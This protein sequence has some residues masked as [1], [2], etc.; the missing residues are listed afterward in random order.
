MNFKLRNA[1]NQRIERI[2]TEHLVIGIDIAKDTHV[3]RAVN[4]RGLEQGR[5]CIFNNHD[6]GFK[7]LEDWMGSLRKSTAASDVIIGME[8]TGHYWLSL[9]ESLQ[10][11]GLEVVVVNPYHVKRNKENRDNSPTKNDLKDALVIA[12]M[13]KNGYYSPLRL[14]SGHFEELRAL[15]SHREFIT[16]QSVS[17]QNQIHRWLAMYFPEYYEVFKDWTCKTSLA[18][19]KLFP[20]P[21]DLRHLRPED[22]IKQWRPYLQRMT[23]ITY[24]QSLIDQARKS[25]GVK[26]AIGRAKQN[27]A[28]LLTLY[29]LYQAQLEELEAQIVPILESIPL[30]ERLL[31]IKGSSITLVSS[32]LAEAGDLRQFEHGQ[33]LLRLAGLHLGEDSSGKHKGQIKITKRG[34]PKLRKALYL[35]MV[36]LVR[37]NPEFRQLHQHNKEVKKIKGIHSLFKLIGKFARILVSISRRGKSYQPDRVL[38]S[39]PP[40][41][42][43]S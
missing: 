28:Q 26:H 2:S 36:S 20:T 7:K 1:Q 10:S 27:L 12:D 6:E 23:S 3:A 39:L 37:N 35:Y 4:Y 9:V 18:T 24:A 11:K 19:L 31:E 21:A 42:I 34:R 13:V 15:V 43:A 22:I 30:A 17:V 33:Q 41:S 8:P 29:D 38:Q 40:L 16:K 5:P 14:P 25:V 32:L